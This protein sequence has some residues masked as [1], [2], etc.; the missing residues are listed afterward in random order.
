MIKHQGVLRLFGKPGKNAPASM[1]IGINHLD[2]PSLYV[3]SEECILLMI[4][5][6]DAFVNDYHKLAF[7]HA[8]LICRH[9]RALI[10]ELH[11]CHLEQEREVS[12]LR[13]HSCR[14]DSA[15]EKHFP[16]DYV[17]VHQNYVYFRPEHKR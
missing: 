8:D 17:S 16:P 5:A 15:N 9:V 6:A 11:L 2:D 12:D 10:N 3:S 13:A 4:E 7:F 1:T 14:K